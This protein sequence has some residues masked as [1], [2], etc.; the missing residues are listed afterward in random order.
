MVLFLVGA[1]FSGCARDK[2]NPNHVDRASNPA[3]AKVRQFSHPREITNPLLPLA[4]LR[5]DILES[6]SERVT[7]TARPDIHQMFVID[8]QSI[9]ALAVEDREMKGG[10]LEEITIDYFAQDDAGN[11]YYLGED[12]NEYKNG[13]IS[14]HDGAW[15]LG[16]ET[17]IPGIIMPM[18]PKVGDHFMSENVPGI[19]WEKDSVVAIA[20]T[21]TTPASTYNGCLKV[22]EKTSDGSTEFKLYA[23][24]IGCI[25]EM[26]ADGDLELTSHATK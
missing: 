26:E 23:P 17:Q 21:I 11:V 25:K 20:E 8:G 3:S 24:G 15:M 7:R 1:V 2:I 13:V 14:G 18:N 12:V 4:S 19:T 9:E 10:Q 5:Q 6:K 22:K 16:R